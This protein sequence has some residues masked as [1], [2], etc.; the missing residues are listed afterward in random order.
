MEL[1]YQYRRE[2]YKPD[3]AENKILIRFKFNFSITSCY[4]SGSGFGALPAGQ[5]PSSDKRNKFFVVSCW[6]I[7]TGQQAGLQN[8]TSVASRV[9]LPY[10]FHCVFTQ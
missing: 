1:Y 5:D 4:E 9:L 8:F 10:H 6:K 7:R 3:S 2:I